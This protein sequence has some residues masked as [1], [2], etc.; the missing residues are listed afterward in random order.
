[1]IAPKAHSVKK[2]IYCLKKCLGEKFLSSNVHI[3]FKR[4]LDVME[5]I[6]PNRVACIYQMFG[7]KLD[8]RNKVSIKSANNR[9]YA[10]AF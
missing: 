9:A 1:M 3:L 10:Y 2:S 8:N 5:S 4:K 7:I 6:I